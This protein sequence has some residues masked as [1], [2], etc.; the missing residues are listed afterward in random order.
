MMNNR[1]LALA[2]IVETGNKLDD[3][4]DM[5]AVLQSDAIQAGDR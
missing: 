1:L 5:R 2:V 4:V 3:R